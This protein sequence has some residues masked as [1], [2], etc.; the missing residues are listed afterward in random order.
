MTAVNGVITFAGVSSL[1]FG[2]VG[3]RAGEHDP[4]GV[5]AARGY[6]KEYVASETPT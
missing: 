3:A 1:P 4:E 6:R 2:G 5:S